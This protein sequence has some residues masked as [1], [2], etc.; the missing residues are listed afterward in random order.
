MTKQKAIQ[1]KKEH[2][3]FLKRAVYV[4]FWFVEISL[5]KQFYTV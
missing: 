5:E 4:I 1:H 2:S 3:V